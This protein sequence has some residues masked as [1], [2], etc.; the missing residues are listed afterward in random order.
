[1][2]LANYL[3]KVTFFVQKKLYNA[4]CERNFY[5][6]GAIVEKHHFWKKNRL[7]FHKFIR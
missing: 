5:E 6:N 3:Y 1:M 4:I 2:L 7:F